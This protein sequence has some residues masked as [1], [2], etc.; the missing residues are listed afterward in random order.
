MEKVEI[1]CLSAKEFHDAAKQIR[2]YRKRTLPKLVEKLIDELSFV[3]EATMMDIMDLHTE[4]EA[5]AGSIER[6]W[7]DSTN[8]NI[9][10]GIVIA[11]DAVLVLEFGSGLAGLGAFNPLSDEI[12][13][14]GPGTAPEQGER[15]NPE[16]ANWE[17]PE[18][19]WYTTDE[20]RTG[21]T[22]GIDPPMPVYN[23]QKAMENEATI[24][25][26]V[27]EVFG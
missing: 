17:N 9:V 13:G 10:V 5:T 15:Q 14:Y 4:T 27:K 24:K 18:G 3:G 26:I 22:F 20:G 19:W 2:K 7:T 1:K 25:K 6:L 12:P 11:S 23:A 16:Y 21:H 8:G